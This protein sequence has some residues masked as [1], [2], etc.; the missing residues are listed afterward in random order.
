[1]PIQD[2]LYIWVATLHIKILIPKKMVISSGS[3]GKKLLNELSL[4]PFLAYKQNLPHLSELRERF[5]ITESQNVFRIFSDW[6]VLVEMCEKGLG[7]TLAPSS[8]LFDKSRCESISI[9]SELI[10]GTDF[11]LVYPKANSNIDWFTD[12]IFEIKSVFNKF[13]LTIKMRFCSF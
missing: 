11:Y 9:S 1:M 10:K 12:L 2:V 5:A 8:F 4:L 3:I 6:Q 7:W 13:N